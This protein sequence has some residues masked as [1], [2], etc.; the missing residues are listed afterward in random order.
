MFCSKMEQYTSHGYNWRLEG[1]NENVKEIA[2]VKIVIFIKYQKHLV[3][4]KN[5]MF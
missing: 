5:D 2:M 1:S 3:I 4:R